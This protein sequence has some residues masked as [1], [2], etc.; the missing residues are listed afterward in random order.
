MKLL[1]DNIIFS[2]QNAGGISVVWSEHIKRIVNESQIDVEFIE[3]QN[4][5][6]FRKEIDLSKEIIKSNTIPVG[7][8]RYLNPLCKEFR[9][10]FHSSYYRYI[11]KPNIINVT[12]VHDF[13]Y[14]YFR[15]GLPKLIHHYQKSSA[16]KNSHKIICVSENTKNDLLNFHPKVDESLIKV[17]YNGVDTIFS[18]LIN[19][20]KTLLQEL[21]P[22]SSGEFVLYVG[23]RKGLYKNFNLVV[24]A[25][26]ITNQP[27]VMVG[28]GGLTKEE[29]QILIDSLGSNGFKHLG[30]INT[31]QLNLIYNNA[32]C[33][34]YPSLYEGFGIPILEAQKTGC[35]VISTNYSSV[36]EVAG[37]G[38]I[39]LDEISIDSIAATLNYMKSN[40]SMLSSLKK[41][42][43]KNAQLFSWDKCYIQTKEL[44]SEI[45]EKYF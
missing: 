12:T 16:I 13:T 28:G 43:Y 44:Y 15:K 29:H 17:I 26:K 10:I 34:L 5:N 39:L 42:G 27:L 23:D 35:P 4:N 24:S 25:C 1:L 2:L 37:E 36:P 3:Y 7:F 45:Y 14:E 31:I 9:G 20:D 8:E 22:F 21:I 6:I 18:P 33:L 19:N 30:G 38:A 32:F 40:S 41:E 11:D